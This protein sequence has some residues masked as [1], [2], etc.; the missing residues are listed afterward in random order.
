MTPPYR[1]RPATA[2]DDAA[3]KALIRAAQIN[4]L[5]LNWRRFWVAVDKNGRLLAC[6]QIKQHRDGA[7]EL[8]S[9]AVIEEW[10]GQGVARAII[11][12]LI[13]GHS[14][15]LWLTCISRLTPFY[16]KFGFVEVTAVAEMPPYF[17]R[18]TRLFRLFRRL[19]ASD[20]YLAVMRF[21]RQGD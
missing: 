13:A 15:P 9:I 11:E 3:I 18:V 4:P 5:G 1:L 19:T 2:A 14:G 12:R 16:E 8:A 6:G 7:H 20:D 21:S 10:R 17:R